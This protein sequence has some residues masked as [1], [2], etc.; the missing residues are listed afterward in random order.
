MRNNTS[1]ALLLFIA[2]LLTCLINAS[3]NCKD[4]KRKERDEALNYHDPRDEDHDE[5]C[6]HCEHENDI[7][8]DGARM[9]G[10]VPIQPHPTCFV[11]PIPNTPQEK[12]LR[13]RFGGHAIYSH[14]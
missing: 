9:L 8:Q 2:L 3:S 13:E 1:L 6:P 7:D 11:E 10:C 4:K 12:V 5:Q 14:F